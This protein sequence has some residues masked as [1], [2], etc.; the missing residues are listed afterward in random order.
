MD[1]FFTE[2]KNTA[3]KVAKKSGE[4]YEL[5]KAKLSMASVKSEISTN[6]KVLGEL[7]YLSQKN[8]TETDA[9]KIEET[10]AKIDVLY[11]RLEELLQSAAA[12]KNEKLCTSCGKS[13]PLSS[14]FCSECGKPF[15]AQEEDVE[16][17]EDIEIL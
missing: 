4:L 3:D 12:L 9:Q 10:I 16:V 5:S 14:A 7:V 13:N 8:V 1:K 6:F 11:E 17:A 15:S 2:I